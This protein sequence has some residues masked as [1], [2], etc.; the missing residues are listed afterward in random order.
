MVRKVILD[1]DPGIDDA[2]ALAMALCD[3]RLDVVAV[4]AVAGN[5]AAEQATRNVQAL[6][7]QIDPPR[8]PR[9]GAASEPDLGSPAD[10]RHLHGSD[11]LGNAHFQVAELH[12]RHRSEKVICDE[13]RAAPG[14][15]SIVAMGPLTNVA[16]ALQ[17]DPE[18]AD[19]IHQIVILGGTLSGPGNV[20]PAAEFNFYCDPSAAQLVLKSTMTRTVVPVDVSGDVT[21]GMDLM[22]K[23]TAIPSRV[24]TLMAKLLPFA[25]RAFR[26]ELGMES[27]QLHDAV[28]LVALLESELFE[29]AAYPVEIETAGSVARGASIFDRRSPPA[30]GPRVTAVTGC[31]AAQVAERIVAGIMQACRATA[32]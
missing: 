29:S 24:A 9:I 21:F 19:M 13:I 14:D 31:D 7:E 2:V 32:D 28:A 12:H 5:V 1:V 18:L 11:G 4:T 10:A 25:F 30:A 22:E 27:I 8:W 23:S 15:V 17:R 16:R 6:I 20:T 3:P 26:Q